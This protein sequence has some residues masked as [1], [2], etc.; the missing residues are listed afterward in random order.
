MLVIEG[1]PPATADDIDAALQ[2]LRDLLG[3][4]CGGNI[5]TGRCDRRHG[6]FL[7]DG[8]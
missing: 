2:D 5:V 6:A 1:L 3:S 7:I 8:N 4:I